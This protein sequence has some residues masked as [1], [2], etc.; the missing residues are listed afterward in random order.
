M[1]S[2]YKNQY[3]GKSRDDFR[4]DE[5]LEVYCWLKEAEEKHLVSDIKYEKSVFE[6]SQN[7]DI[8]YLTQLKTKTKICSK[9]LLKPHIYTPD[10]EFNVTGICM[11]QFFINTSYLH[12]E[13]VIIDVK[14]SF[15]KFGDPKQ[16][17]INQKWVYSKF[18]EYIE[19]IVPEK[20][21][22]KTFAPKI[23]LFTPSTG[24]RSTSKKV[25]GCK[26]INEFMEER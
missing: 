9:H 22:K 23:C 4:S 6:L 17:A 7:Q 5:E 20:L 10:F 2:K 24:K 8:S 1:K 18:D 25:K 16:F 12:K 26:S 13:T 14:G 19:K 21:F 11:Y 15:N 3:F